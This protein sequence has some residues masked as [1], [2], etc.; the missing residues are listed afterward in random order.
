MRAKTG[1]LHSSFLPLIMRC[2]F[3]LLDGPKFAHQLADELNAEKNDVIWC[4]KILKKHNLV[5]DEKITRSSIF[6]TSTTRWKAK[7]IL[8]ANI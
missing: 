3:A 2:Y 1:F 7:N 4:L 8:G 5:E 6:I